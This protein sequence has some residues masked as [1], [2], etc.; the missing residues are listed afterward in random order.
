MIF[1]GLS[2]SHDVVLARGGLKLEKEIAARPELVKAEIVYWNNAKDVLQATQRIFNV[3]PVASA[4]STS[5]SSTHQEALSTVESSDSKLY[6]QP[7]RA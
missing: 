2:S 1:F 3:S 5:F 6:A 7:V 4:P